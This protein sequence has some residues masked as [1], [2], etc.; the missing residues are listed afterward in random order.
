[1]KPITLF[2]VIIGTIAALNAFVE[3][4]AMTGGGPN[5]DLAGPRFLFLLARDEERG[6]REY[7]RNPDREFIHVRVPPAKINENGAA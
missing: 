5:V 4:Y 6:G 2:M 3:V 7:N 1:M